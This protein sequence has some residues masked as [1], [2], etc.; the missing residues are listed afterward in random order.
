MEKILFQVQ[1]VHIQD[2][3]C[4]QSIYR[5][6][7]ERTLCACQY[8]RAFQP[9]YPKPFEVLSPPTPRLALAQRRWCKNIIRELN[10]QETSPSLKWLHDDVEFP[11]TALLW[12]GWVIDFLPTLLLS[13]T[14][15]LVV[16]PHSMRLFMA[17]WLELGSNNGF[18][19]CSI[20]VCPGIFSLEQVRE[21]YG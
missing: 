7:R 16:D 5:V 18:F 8:L 1:A 15:V 4:W 14:N 20:R 3:I 10:M 6:F 21:L 17:A 19:H 11:F 13:H 9:R 2:P 12:P